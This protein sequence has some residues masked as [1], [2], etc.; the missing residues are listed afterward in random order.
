MRAL[1]C[2]LCGEIINKNG[3][4]GANESFVGGAVF[5]TC[6][7]CIEKILDS[8]AEIQSEHFTT[9]VEFDPVVNIKEYTDSKR[10]KEEE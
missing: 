6:D 4:V 7:S 8:V 3:S 5:A 2:D 10:K 1:F 9:F